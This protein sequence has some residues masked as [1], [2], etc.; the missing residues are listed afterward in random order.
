MNIG[1]GAVTKFPIPTADCGPDGMVLGPDQNG[2]VGKAL[3][4]A[5]YVGNRI[6]RLEVSGTGAVTMKEFSIPT[7]N[8]STDD[9]GL[10]PNGDPWF[11][12][13]NGNKISWI[14]PATNHIT[15]YKIPTANSGPFDMI[16]G[17]DGNVWFT[18]RY[19][20]RI[21]RFSPTG[22]NYASVAVCNSCGANLALMDR[23]PDGNVWFAEPGVNK[24]VESLRN[25]RSPSTTRAVARNRSA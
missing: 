24:W 18:A 22:T 3:W 21:G 25:L 16:T 8:S 12:E 17:S 20:N 10:G 1:T 7:S 6:G 23:G 15:E 14:N 19:A 13:Q 9:V 4:F 2:R 11:T 5:D